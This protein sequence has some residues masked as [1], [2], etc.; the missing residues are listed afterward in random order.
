MGSKV[1]D[2]MGGH[3]A[4]GSGGDCWGAPGPIGPGW[5][6]QGDVWGQTWGGTGPGPPPSAAAPHRGGGAGGTIGGTRGSQHRGPGAG[7]GGSNPPRDKTHQP[8]GPPQGTQRTLA[9]GGPGRSRGIYCF[10]QGRAV[11]QPHLQGDTDTHTPPWPPPANTRWG[12]KGTRP[13]GRP[14]PP[15]C[16]PPS[17]L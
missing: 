9:P 11:G 6:V 7:W 12:G 2:R 8:P 3:R 10:Q 16:A 4:L 13:V 15:S 5:G 1:R 14:A 17:P